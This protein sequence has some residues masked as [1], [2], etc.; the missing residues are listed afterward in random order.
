MRI[1]LRGHNATCMCNEDVPYMVR[2]ITGEKL[3]T[4]MVTIVHA[5]QNPPG[6]DLYRLEYDA[7]SGLSVVRML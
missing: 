7:A 1:V 6:E 2:P 4:F 5:D 3:A